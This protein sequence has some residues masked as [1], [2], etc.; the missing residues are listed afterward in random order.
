MKT[1]D[2]KKQLDEFAEMNGIEEYRIDKMILNETGFC[3]D[4]KGELNYDKSIDVYITPIKGC[5][6]LVTSVTIINN[7]EL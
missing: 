5:S 2:L 7:N 3:V 1:I 4:F 6:K